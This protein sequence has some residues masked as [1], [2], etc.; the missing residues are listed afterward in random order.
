VTA[1]LSPSKIG[2]LGIPGLDGLTSSVSG[3]LTQGLASLATQFPSLAGFL[4]GN[5]APSTSQDVAKTNTEDAQKIAASVLAVKSKVIG[6]ALQHAQ[7][8]GEYTPGVANEM[9]QQ[10]SKAMAAATTG[11][12]ALQANQQNLDAAATDAKV[13]KDIAETNYDNSLDALAG[14]NKSLA[15]IARGQERINSALI[16]S[17]TTQGQLLEQTALLRDTANQSNLRHD[18][19]IQHHVETQNSLRCFQSSIYIPNLTCK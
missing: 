16:E 2:N 15:V 10:S 13:A 7:D 19:A 9:I 17:K 11:K 1:S 6:D 12:A 3:L 4:G 14:A 5:S 8:T 18:T